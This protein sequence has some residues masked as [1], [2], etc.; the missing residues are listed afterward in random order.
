MGF[1]RG[2]QARDLVKEIPVEAPVLDGLKQVRCLDAFGCRQIGDRPSDLQDAV[3]SARRQRKLLHGLLQKVS[4]RGINRTIRADLRVGHAGVGGCA[5]TLEPVELAAAR[6]LHAGADIGGRFPMF[7]IAELGDGKRRRFDVQVD[8]VEQR[9]ADARSVA[10]N[11]G[12]RA[13]ALVFGVT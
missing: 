7:F 2:R 3:I 9:T 6:S 4:Q 12:G 11:L 5:G 8:T 10:L 1:S 13:P